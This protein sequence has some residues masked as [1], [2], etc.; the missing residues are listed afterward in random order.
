MAK[1]RFCLISDMDDATLLAAAGRMS[2]ELELR[3]LPDVSFKEGYK[4][5]FLAALKDREI[6]LGQV[7]SP[8]LGRRL[9]CE[10]E[11][12]FGA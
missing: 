4:R 1:R 5:G 12:R 9:C 2:Q 3:G 6:G 7:W 8:E 11:R 10:L